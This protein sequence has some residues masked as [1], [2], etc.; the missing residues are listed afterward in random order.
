MCV[1]TH[2]VYGLEAR[3][4]APTKKYTIQRRSG[5]HGAELYL[6]TNLPITLLRLQRAFSPEPLLVNVVIDTVW[7]VRECWTHDRSRMQLAQGHNP[8]EVVRPGTFVAWFVW[9]GFDFGW[10]GFWRRNF[11][12]TRSA[13]WL[14]LLSGCGQMHCEEM[15]TQF[16]LQITYF[17]GPR[18][19]QRIPVRRV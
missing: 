12:N 15:K 5:Y 7:T 6:P 18:T 2:K 14:R 19:R 9:E 4:E 16:G 13:R 17:Q 8:S 10:K 11:G 1:F 3:R